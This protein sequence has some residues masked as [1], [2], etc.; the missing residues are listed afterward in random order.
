MPDF[1][2]NFMRV[3]PYN[4]NNLIEEWKGVKPGT[5]NVKQEKT[6]L[7]TRHTN[8]LSTS[9]IEL[10]VD[11]E[12][13]VRRPSLSREN[14]HQ[15]V[16]TVYSIND[17]NR[18]TNER[19]LSLS[20]TQQDLRPD[21]PE[22]DVSLTKENE[23]LVQQN[24][25]DRSSTYSK[26]RIDTDSDGIYLP[27]PE[28]DELSPVGKSKGRNRSEGICLDEQNSVIL[29]EDVNFLSREVT[30]YLS[31]DVKS[32]DEDEMIEYIKQIY[33]LSEACLDYCKYIY[34]N[35]D[36]KDDNN[37]KIVESI[38]NANDKYHALR[39]VALKT[40]KLDNQTN[41]DFIFNNTMILGNNRT[42][43]KDKGYDFMNSISRNVY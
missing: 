37:L 9:E 6:E 1:K 34:D 25:H 18:I 42:V 40:C 23:K 7:D 3:N 39:Y 19:R 2:P 28:N 35:V 22:D 5:T 32:F 17:Q 43:A 30:E 20:E 12:L 24:G 36:F 38:I 16:E 14:Q 15:R 33:N 11:E 31:K 27:V 41:L 4:F 21:E 10:L 13:T 8:N 26:S 29:H